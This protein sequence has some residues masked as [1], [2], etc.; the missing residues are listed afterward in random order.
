MNDG[1]ADAVPVHPCVH[2]SPESLSHAIATCPTRAD[3]EH[4]LEINECS[5]IIPTDLLLDMNRVV[6]RAL[7]G[8]QQ[9]WNRVAQASRFW[10]TCVLVLAIVLFYFV[11]GK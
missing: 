5:S 4:G 7:E 2:H 10:D 8:A 9:R 1:D 3:A 6:Q 11:F